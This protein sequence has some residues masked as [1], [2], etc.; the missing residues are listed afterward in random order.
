MKKSTTCFRRRPWSRPG[1]PLPDGNAVACPCDLWLWVRLHHAHKLGDVLHQRV[2]SFQGSADKGGCTKEKKIWKP[3]SDPGGRWPRQRCP[4]RS[5]DGSL[6]HAAFICLLWLR[7]PCLCYLHSAVIDCR[8]CVF[9]SAFSTGHKTEHP[10]IQDRSFFQNQT[11]KGPS[12]LPDIWH[13]YCTPCLFL[14]F[15][16]QVAPGLKVQ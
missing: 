14:T 9:P 13:D 5:P 16:N 12:V 3:P 4:C 11:P 15:S 10:G 8:L 2:H 6:L 7:S 1:G